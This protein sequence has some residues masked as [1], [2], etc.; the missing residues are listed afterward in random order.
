MFGK[1]GFVNEGEIRVQQ[2]FLRAQSNHFKLFPVRATRSSYVDNCSHNPK[3][4]GSNP[5]PATTFQRLTGAAPNPKGAKRCKS[6]SRK[7]RFA[8]YPQD[9]SQCH[10]N[11][12]AVCLSLGRGHRCSS[13]DVHSRLDRGVSHQFLL[14]RHRC[15]G[16]LKP[17]AVGVPKRMPA[18]GADATRELN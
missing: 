7:A 10:P 8:F 17:S 12:V 18:D 9:R 16:F 13:I 6:A 14:D 5:A 2:L 15:A 11:H 4:A 1:K 3:V